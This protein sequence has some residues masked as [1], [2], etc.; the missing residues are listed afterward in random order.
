MDTKGVG[1]DALPRWARAV[2][3]VVAASA[4]V[5]VGAAL[6]Q[7]NSPWC[8]DEE[9]ADCPTEVRYDDRMYVVDCTDPVPAALRDEAVTVLYHDGGE[10]TERQ[11]WTLDG[12]PRED[13]VVLD[14]SGSHCDGT[15]MA[16]GENLSRTEARALLRTLG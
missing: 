13:L 12:V 7:P 16:Y 5:A 4:V 15:E 10:E 8:D 3:A 9:G 1:V 11:A 2:L 6:W 14:G